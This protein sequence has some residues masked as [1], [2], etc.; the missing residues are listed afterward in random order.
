M[1]QVQLT[2]AFNRVRELRQART[3]DG[4]RRVSAERLAVLTGIAL[5]RMKRLEL[6]ESWSTIPERRAVANELSRIPVKA[7]GRCERVTPQQTG[8]KVHPRGAT[9]GPRP[10][11][12]RELEPAV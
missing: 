6:E 1:P 11:H 3:E 2:P 7:T 5:D 4:K 9:R 12:M 8:L 10:A